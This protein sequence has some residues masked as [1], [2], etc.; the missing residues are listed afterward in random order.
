M[1]PD[2]VSEIRNSNNRAKPQNGLEVAVML[3]L[4]YDA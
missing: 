2:S 3:G 1:K 4:G